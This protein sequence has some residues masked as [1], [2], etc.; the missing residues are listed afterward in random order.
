MCTCFGL[1][2]YMYMYMCRLARPPRPP[3]LSPHQPSLPLS[4]DQRRSRKE[5][6]LASRAVVCPASAPP[7]RFLRGRAWRMAA[8]SSSIPATSSSSPEVPACTACDVASLAARQTKRQG[9][10]PPTCSHRSRASQIDA[11]IGKLLEVRGSRPGK[12]VNLTEAEMCA[13][14]RSP[15][16]HW[17]RP[18]PLPLSRKR[19]PLNSCPLSSPRRRAAAICARLPAR[20]S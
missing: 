1:V 6:A 15:P 2:L 9:A 16:A 11:V 4:C 20:S 3:A 18:A 12:Q 13:L 5:E 14:A 17:V 8:A 7:R 10:F 19:P